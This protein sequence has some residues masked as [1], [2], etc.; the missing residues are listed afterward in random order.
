[1]RISTALRNILEKIGD[2]VSLDLLSSERT[3]QGDYLGV[4]SGYI[5][6]LPAG[7]P[8]DK[9][10]ASKNRMRVK[11]ARAARKFCAQEHTD[12]EYEKFHNSFES[13]AFSIKN[14]ELLKGDDIITA[15]NELYDKRRQSH[16]MNSCMVG[17]GKHRFKLY[18]D[19]PKHVRLLVLWD[20]FKGQDVIIARALLWK[21]EKGIYV[22]R[23]YGSDTARPFIERYVDKKGWMRYGSGY[24]QRELVHTGILVRK[25]DYRGGQTPYLDTFYLTSHRTDPD[26]Y[27]VQGEIRVR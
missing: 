26:H 21:T 24:G 13:R 15:Y 16:M 3:D 22:D 4:R 20:R 9:P 25:D 1:M 2:D 14:I 11:P 5:T 23:V 7:K 12:A 6:Y 19:N 17:V 18:T 8:N 27:I 10:Y